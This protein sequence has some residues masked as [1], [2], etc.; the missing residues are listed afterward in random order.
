MTVLNAVAVDVKMPVVKHGDGLGSHG[1]SLPCFLQMTSP[2]KMLMMLISILTSPPEEVTVCVIVVNWSTMGEIVPA[3]GGAVIFAGLAT[4]VAVWMP[5]LRLD[6]LLGDTT[7]GVAVGFGGLSTKGTVSV[8]VLE[9]FG[10]EE[11]LERVT[12]AVLELPGCSTT[13]TVSAVEFDGLLAKVAVVE[14]CLVGLLVRVTVAVLGLAGFSTNVTVSMVEFPALLSEAVAAVLELAGFSTEVT[15]S[16]VELAEIA[17]EG[18]FASVTVV[19]LGPAGLSTNVT[20]STLGLG[21]GGFCTTVTVLIP[22]FD[23][24]V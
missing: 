13:V 9:V 5:V 3:C 16:V 21:A 24:A 11:L 22:G 6:E 8:V 15:V 2:V 23:S 19:V 4:E 14:L 20:V 1:S 10:L 7:S 12:V 17:F 18:L